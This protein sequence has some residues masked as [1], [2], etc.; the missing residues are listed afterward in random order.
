MD[1]LRWRLNIINGRSISMKLNRNTTVKDK[2]PDSVK[3]SLSDLVVRAFSDRDVIVVLM[4]AWAARLFFMLMMPPGARSFDT[5]SWESVAKVLD[6]GKNPYQTT[7]FLNWPPLWLQLIFVISKISTAFSI[8]FFRVLQTFLILV[9]S[10]VIIL[11]IKLIREIAPTASIR[12]LV[13]IGLALNPAAIFLICQ[14]CNFDVIMALWLMLFMLGLLRYNRARNYADW[15]CACLF[16]GLG[17]LT[18]TVPL[19]LAPLLAGGF[20][21]AT[22]RLKFLGLVL[23]LGPV[24]LGISIIYVLAPTDIATK[25]FSYR[26]AGGS[27]G[28]S[29]L[30]HLAGVDE[31]TGFYNVIF[32]I[33]LFMVM[34]VSSILFWHR[35][36][37]GSRE[38]VLL[39]ALLLAG[40]PALGPGYAP[41]YLYW[42]MP[43]LVATFACFKGRWRLVLTGFA[44]IA[45]CT[46]LVEYALV[47]A[48]GMFLLK[49]LAYNKETLGQ[50]VSLLPMI[51]KCESPT[52]LTLIRLPIFAAYL[53]LIVVGISVLLRGIKGQLKGD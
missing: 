31:L 19:V 11:L 12:K 9:E 29:G 23:L 52:G 16:L 53:A 38:T 4:V 25:V 5:Y 47:G 50:A 14:H 30:F 10:A 22:T 26:S 33:L 48:N 27:F 20:R 3:F 35:Q 32:Y 51:R 37:V 28:F 44:L 41:Q 36:S 7:N 13:I 34:V 49:I 15:L 45:V 46:Y 24:A 21:A 18:K 6:A 39:A 43:F 42:F 1:S 17:I 40:V 8:P 2:S